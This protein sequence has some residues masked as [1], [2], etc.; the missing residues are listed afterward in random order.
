M[1]Y[2]KQLNF[3]KAGADNG[4]EIYKFPE[5]N[6]DNKN[7]KILKLGIQSIPGTNFN[8]NNYGNTAQKNNVIDATGIFELDL[9]NLNMR[10]TQFDFPK[11]TYA[12]ID[13]IYEID[14][15]YIEEDEDNA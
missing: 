9:S 13:M 15:S 2:Y 1:Q 7:A 12:I 6:M 10:I 5:D 14:D 3:P 11:G 8:I 4:D